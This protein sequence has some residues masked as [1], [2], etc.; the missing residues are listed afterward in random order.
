MK[1]MVLHWNVF[2]VSYGTPLECFLGFLPIVIHKTEE[3][4]KAVVSH[5]IYINNCRGQPYDSASNMVAIYS[6]LQE[7]LTQSNLLANYVP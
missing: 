3:M 6:G 7:R 1:L 4:E 5:Q 2:L